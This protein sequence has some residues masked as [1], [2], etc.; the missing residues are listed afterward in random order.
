MLKT[1]L[2]QTVQDLASSYELGSLT[3]STLQS[4]LVAKK[5]LKGLQFNSDAEIKRPI[6]KIFQ[7]IVSGKVLPKCGLYYA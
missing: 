3:T 1:I 4:Q 6:K 5:S 2:D 7:K